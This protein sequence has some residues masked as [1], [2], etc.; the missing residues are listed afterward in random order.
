MRRLIFMA[1]S[2]SAMLAI[3]P[4]A[5]QSA[6]ARAC[7][8]MLQTLNQQIG[9]SRSYRMVLGPDTYRELRTLRSTARWLDRN[10]EQELCKD[11]VGAAQRLLE[12]QR[13]LLA[14]PKGR[15]RFGRDFATWNARQIERLRGAIPVTAKGGPATAER[16]IGA[17]LRNPDNQELGVVSDLA[18]LGDPRT[19]SYAVVSHGGLFDLGDTTVAVPWDLL[20]VVDD[21]EILVLDISP[22]DLAKAPALQLDDGLE[23]ADQR[24]RDEN[25]RFFE[26]STR[27]SAAGQ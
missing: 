18:L 11:M 22:E 20:K 5:A 2:L 19:V 1:V 3:R 16:I 10:G 24:W 12:T 25:R 27:A 8:D 21:W 9:M 23:L 26:Q 6:D 15:E 4:A 13:D 7:D 14:T 17:T